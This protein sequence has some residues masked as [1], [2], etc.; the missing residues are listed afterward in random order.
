MLTQC[1]SPLIFSANCH[2]I[3]TVERNVTMS[4]NNNLMVFCV[5]LRSNQDVDE[6]PDSDTREDDLIT[7]ID[8]KKKKEIK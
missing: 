8:I 3:V 6:I 5:D 2:T 7:L 4:D 1:R